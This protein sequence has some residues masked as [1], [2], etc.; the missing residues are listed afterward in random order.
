MNIYEYNFKV[1][2]NKGHFFDRNGLHTH[3]ETCKM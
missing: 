1:S 2:L 3:T